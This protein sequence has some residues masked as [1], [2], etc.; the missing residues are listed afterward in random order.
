MDRAARALTGATRVA[1]PP[2]RSTS[3]RPTERVPVAEA[4]ARHAG[5]DLAGSDGDARPAPRRRA[6]S[7]LDRG[8][9]GDGFDDLFFRV[10]LERVEPAI[11]A[12]GRPFLRVD[13]PASMAALARAQGPD[14]R[15]AERFELYAGGLEL[16]N[17]FS[18]LTDAAEQRRRLRR[19]SALRRRLGRPVYPLDERVP[20]RGREDA[21]S[22]R[23]GGGLDRLLMLLVGARTIE[24]VLLFP[25]SGFLA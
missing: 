9:P 14:P 5:V 23:R 6:A 20:G 22:R 11:A 12:G 1:P 10:F 24:E 18:E 15:V 7:G 3:P 16:A 13:W 4:F 8:Q 19:S 2:A 21:G 25:A 17:G